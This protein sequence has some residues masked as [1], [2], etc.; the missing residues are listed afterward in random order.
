MC[1]RL[2]ERREEM[3]TRRELVKLSPEAY[4]KARR[5]KNA[6]SRR[7]YVLDPKFYPCFLF[8]EDVNNEAALL[9]KLHGHVNV[10]THCGM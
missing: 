10:T 2:I 3:R 9:S 1:R 5:G 8:D 6:W 7:E 4:K